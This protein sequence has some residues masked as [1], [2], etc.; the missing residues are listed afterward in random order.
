MEFVLFVDVWVASNQW[1]CS[2]ILRGNPFDITTCHNYISTI[3]F[4]YIISDTAFLSP[5]CLNLFPCGLGT[6]ARRLYVDKETSFTCVG[7]IGLTFLT[8]SFVRKMSTTERFD[9]VW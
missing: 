2:L 9:P 1:Q 6:V 3:M 5:I 8:P 4:P 7:S